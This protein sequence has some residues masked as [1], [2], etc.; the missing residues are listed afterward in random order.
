MIITPLVEVE[1]RHIV[2]RGV[3]LV[4]V[5]AAKEVRGHGTLRL[6]PHPGTE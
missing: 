3:N 4:R 6:V 1:E 5:K 2:L